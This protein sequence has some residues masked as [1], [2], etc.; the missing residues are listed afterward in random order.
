MGHA[1]PCRIFMPRGDHAL[2]GIGPPGPGRAALTMTPISLSVL[3]SELGDRYA[4]KLLAKDPYDSCH[5]SHDM[6]HDV[7]QVLKLKR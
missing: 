2:E 7:L 5:V 6:Q 1:M 4:Q 3:Q